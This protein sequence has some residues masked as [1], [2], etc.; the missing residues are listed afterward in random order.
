MPTKA[1]FRYVNEPQ[2]LK[3]ATSQCLLTVSVGQE[4]HE[5]EKFEST[6]ELINQHFDSCILLVDDS[7]QRHTMALDQLE[8]A[9]FFYDASMTAGDAWLERNEKYYR[10]LTSLKKIL[11]W[12]VWL[13]HPRYQETKC[14][15]QNELSTDSEYHEA[16]SD[17]VGEF[18]RRYIPRANAQHFNVDRAKQ[19]CEDYLL[20]ECTALCLWHETGSHFEVYPSK[21]N[22]AMTKTHEKFIL[23]HNPALLH[24][25]GIKFK[26]RKQL[27]PQNFD[28][29]KITENMEN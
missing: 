19:L 14:T 6:I 10:K 4:V 21:R 7:L 8:N 26:N 27:K 9:D 5:G 3:F 28:F 1:V 23:P 24:S 15:I 17:T 18:L 11:R 20:E 2:K 25:V 13:K 12:D 16:F 29:S 22:Q